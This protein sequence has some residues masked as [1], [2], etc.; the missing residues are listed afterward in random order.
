MKSGLNRG[1]SSCGVYANKP[2]A[3]G[4]DLSLIDDDNIK[5]ARLKIELIYAKPQMIPC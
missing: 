4:L 1:N 3:L 5:Y 2:H